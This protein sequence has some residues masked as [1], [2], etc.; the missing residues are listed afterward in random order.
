M[1]GFAADPDQI[2]SHAAKVEAVAARFAAV[3]GASAHIIANDAAYGLLCGWI[4]GVLEGR[5]HRQDEL[6]AYV[7][8]N[9][10]LSADALR[11]TAEGYEAVDSDANA[12]IADAGRRVGG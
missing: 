2:R 5:H 3:K 12:S 11:R 9:L 8:E 7:E 4:S 6:L 10:R 1:T